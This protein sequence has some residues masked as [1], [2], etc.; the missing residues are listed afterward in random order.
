MPDL[1]A[2][3][4]GVNDETR[5]LGGPLR[6]AFAYLAYATHVRSLFWY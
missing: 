6:S 3:L 4:R 2:L 5:R 1:Q